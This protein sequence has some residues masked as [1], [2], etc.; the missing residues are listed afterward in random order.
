MLICESWRPFLEAMSTVFE[1]VLLFCVLMSLGCIEVGEI[2][3]IG[4]VCG[5]GEGGMR[6]L[7]WSL[8]LGGELLWCRSILVRKLVGV[9]E[10]LA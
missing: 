6:G 4:F 5:L 3:H 7:V 8:L 10:W 1:Y 2:G 9:D